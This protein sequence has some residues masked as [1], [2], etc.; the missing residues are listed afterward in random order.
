[1]PKYP[2]QL[3][4]KVSDR[5]LQIITKNAEKSGLSVCAYL[6]ER[7]VGNPV[8][9]LTDASTALSIDKFGRMLKNLQF[10]GPLAEI[11]VAELRE[12][13]DFMKSGSS[14]ENQKD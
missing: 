7:A 4:T 1:M 12:L 6:R 5:E 9:S 14:H 2:N 13:K 3:R 11:V 8:Q 10:H